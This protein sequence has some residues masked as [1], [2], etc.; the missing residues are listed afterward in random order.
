MYDSYSAAVGVGDCPDVDFFAVYE[1]G[2]GVGRADAA[3]DFYQGALARPVLAEQRM[4]FT[5]AKFEIDAFECEDTA[6]V[7]SYALEKEQRRIGGFFFCR[8]RGVCSMRIACE[9]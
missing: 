6:E 2:S 1:Y 5:G 3:E 4:D 9:R 8:N 7:F